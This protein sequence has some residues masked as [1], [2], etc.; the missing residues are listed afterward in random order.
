MDIHRE[1]ASVKFKTELNR[2]SL[3]ARNSPECT[4]HSADQ[5]ERWVK[6]YQFL[7]KKPI[8]LQTE[9]ELQMKSK[10]SNREQNF[11]RT[12]DQFKAIR[13]AIRIT[14]GRMFGWLHF[15]VRNFRIKLFC[16]K[17]TVELWT[18]LTG[19][20]KYRRD[21]LRVLSPG[22]EIQARKSGENVQWNDLIHVKHTLM[23]IKR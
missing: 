17:W 16:R 4:L 13:K 12:A 10:I 14:D 3:T 6:T 15:R 11:K 7:W 23:D 20:C 22:T 8:K 5:R 18:R 2:P 1:Q 9:S 19:D 21:S